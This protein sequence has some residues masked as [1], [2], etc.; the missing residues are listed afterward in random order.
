V[1]FVQVELAVAVQVSGQLAVQ[2]AQQGVGHG[3]M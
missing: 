2:H 1:H 3:A